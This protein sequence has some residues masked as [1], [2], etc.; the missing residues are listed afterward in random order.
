MTFDFGSLAID[1]RCG[2][3]AWGVEVRV[4]AS[5][6]MS[7]PAGAASAHRLTLAHSLLRRYS[8]HYIRS[9][10]ERGESVT[11]KSDAV[12]VRVFR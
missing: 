9:I 4:V 2:E 12:R 5:A 3:V 7:L 10:T 11:S 1:L 6:N 8:S